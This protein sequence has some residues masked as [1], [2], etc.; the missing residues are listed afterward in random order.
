M[1]KGTKITLAVIGLAVLFAV[2]FAIYKIWFEKPEAPRQVVSQTITPAQRAENEKEAAWAKY[3][4]VLPLEKKAYGKDNQSDAMGKANEAYNAAIDKLKA[5]DYNKAIAGFRDAVKKY[6]A[7]RQAD[8]IKIGEYQQAKKDAEAAL[9]EVTAAVAKGDMIAAYSATIRVAVAYEEVSGDF[10]PPLETLKKNAT[11]AL[12]GL[13]KDKIQ[14]GV[15]DGRLTQ[16]VK[17]AAMDTAFK[18]AILQ[19]LKDAGKNPDETLDLRNKANEVMQNMT[20]DVLEKIGVPKEV[21]SWLDITPSFDWQPGWQP[22]AQD[23]LKKPW[24]DLG[25]SDAARRILAWWFGVHKKEWAKNP[26]NL[27]N[28]YQSLKPQIFQVLRLAGVN[29]LK[30]RQE[31][32][33]Y[34]DGFQKSLKPEAMT[35][36]RVYTKFQDEYD[37]LPED[38]D[39]AEALKERADG[40][41][42]DWNNL[43]QKNPDEPLFY[44]TDPGFIGF[45][46]LLE[47]GATYVQT[48]IRVCDDA[49]ATI[50]NMKF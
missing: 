50:D 35:A 9:K 6:D 4:E 42:K 17:P 26:I 48:L 7:V 28:F 39:K 8:E 3:N 10:N 15:K 32:A 16:Q 45:R 29:P 2:G 25:L 13:C 49:I 44:E 41:K 33:R 23:E 21:A 14:E 34:R 43:L 19:A 30:Y 5:G 31:I 24:A 38:S 22:P 40:A 47:G 27:W 1:K 18:T 20:S 11:D 12:S 37:A 36:W 46:R